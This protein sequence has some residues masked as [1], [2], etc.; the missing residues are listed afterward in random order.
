VAQLA[1]PDDLIRPRPGSLAPCNHSLVATDAVREAPVFSAGGRSFN[2]EDV[3]EAA[4]A[5][6]DWQE[7][8]RQTRE[9]LE[10]ERLVAAAGELPSTTEVSGAA[11]A[12]RYERNLLAADELQHW[13]ARWE[14]SVDEWLAFIRRSLLTGRPAVAEDTSVSEGELAR[15]TWVRA[16]CS[17]ELRTFARRF[18]EQIAVHVRLHD[19]AAPT[20]P[21]GETFEPADEVDRFCRSQLTEQRLA[22]EVAANLIGWTRLECHYLVHQD[23]VVL[24]EAALCVT[25]DGRELDEVANDAA[26]ELKRVSFY[27]DDI[28]PSLRTRLLAARPGDLLEPAPM[29]D[30]YWLVLVVDRVPPTLEDAALRARAAQAITQRALAAEVSKTVR[31]HEHL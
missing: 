25:E 1:K 10:L 2:W 31:W 7:L 24:R 13:L 20:S 22:T 21:G 17:G 15:A 12:F 30:A 11:N 28:E 14:I 27:L 9:L 16:V 23:P 6:G 26:L 4:G 5:R 18:A 8:E 29:N 3:I 19:E